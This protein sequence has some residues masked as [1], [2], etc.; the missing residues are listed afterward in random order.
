MAP[1]VVV[2]RGREERSARRGAD[3]EK[4]SLRL[5]RGGRLRL[6]VAAGVYDGMPTIK[7]MSLSSIRV[8]FVS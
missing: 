3:K 5:E 8:D 2:R 1:R 6:G 4:T 7:V